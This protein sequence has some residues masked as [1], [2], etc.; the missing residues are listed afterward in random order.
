MKKYNKLVRSEIPEIIKAEGKQCMY[1]TLDPIKEED[2]TEVIRLLKQKLVEEAQ[3]VLEA[4]TRG[5]VL[6]E[7]ADLTAVFDTLVYEL[8]E[9]R[10]GS[11]KKLVLDQIDNL[12]TA[13]SIKNG[14]FQYLVDQNG[15]KVND[16]YTI[17]YAR[18]IKLLSVQ[19]KNG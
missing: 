2:K 14:D 12:K 11:D 5:Q 9:Q 13:K 7:L 17:G 8:C 18:Y 10:F 1:I 3:E 6:E 19:D 15:K 16:N 4:K